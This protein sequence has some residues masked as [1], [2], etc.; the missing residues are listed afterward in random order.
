MSAPKRVVVIGS[1]FAGLTAAFDVKRKVGKNVHVT[2]ITD[3]PLFTFIPSLIWV[4]QGWRST[5]DITFLVEPVFARRGIETMVAP[6]TCIDPQ[7]NVVT[8]S[9]GEVPYDYLVIATGAHLNF[10]AVPGLGPHE[11][12]TQSVCNLQHALT[13]QLAWVDYLKDPGPIVVG[14]AQGASCFGAGYEFVLNIEYALRRSGLRNQASV[15]WFTSEPFLGHFGIWGVKDSQKQVKRF[16]ERYGIEGIPN[17]AI[18]AVTPD[19]IHLSNGRELPYKFA[20]VIPPFQGV[21]AIRNSPGQVGNASG[22]IEVDDNYRHRHYPNIYAAGV[23]V[24]MSP[25]IPTEI[26]TGVPKTAYMS[27]VMARAAAH[28]IAAD[29]KNER[30]S[31]LPIMDI[32]ALCLLDAGDSGMIM[33]VDKVFGEKRKREILMPGSLM[34]MGK[35]AFENYFLWKSRSGRTF[36][37]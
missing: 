28:N 25:P 14:A 21:E 26:P 2:V 20:M 19:T 12:Y 32:Q 35:V 5:K 4:T 6:A 30:P 27:E 10:A 23:A 16:F 18:E 33:L 17:V 11:G 9:R 22:W 7:R 8:T 31:S 34:H 29:I 3:N 1:N 37:P 36:L 13:S 24:A 15:T